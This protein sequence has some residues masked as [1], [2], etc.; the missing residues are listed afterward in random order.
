MATVPVASAKL[1]QRPCQVI[2]I[3]LLFVGLFA[4]VNSLVL[5]G[6]RVSVIANSPHSLRQDPRR[7]GARRSERLLPQ[8]EASDLFPAGKPG[9]GYCLKNVIK[10][11]LLQMD[12]KKMR[13]CGRYG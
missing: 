5:R 8:I 1:V 12:E 2:Q 9:G 7:A 10:P 4:T 11:P 3:S 6:N 13:A